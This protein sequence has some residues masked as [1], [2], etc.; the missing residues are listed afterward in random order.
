MCDFESSQV[1]WYTGAE[2]AINSIYVLCEKPDVMCEG[3]IRKMAAH[4]FT[5]ND[6]LFEQTP[7]NVESKQEKLD[8]SVSP[9]LF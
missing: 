3:L 5:H 7:L 4:I 9:F 6:Q 8:L 1:K 2:Q